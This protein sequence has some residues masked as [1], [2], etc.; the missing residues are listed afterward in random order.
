VFAARNAANTSS[1]NQEQRY[2]SLQEWRQLE[3]YRPEF[4]RLLQG[5]QRT[6]EIQR[7]LIRVTQPLDVRDLLVCF[8]GKLETWRCG[9]DP[10]FEQLV[11]RKAAERVI[12]L[13][14][15]Q[16]RRVKAQEF[17]GSEL[18]GIKIGFPARISPTGSACVNLR[19]GESV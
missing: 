4:L 1:L 9:G 13:D 5:P 11:R 6:D 2:V 7:E 16:A 12:H 17:R 19:H 10:A 3:E 8:H 14:G 18:G 15:V